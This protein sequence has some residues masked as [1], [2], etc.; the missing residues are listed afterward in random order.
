MAYAS[1]QDVEARGGGVVFSESDASSIETFIEDFSLYLDITIEQAGKDPVTMNQQ[2]L[3]VIAARRALDYY[4]YSEK[5]GVSSK[6]EA[7]GDISQT[8][9]FEASTK[10]SDDFMYLTPRD[11]Q[12]LGMNNSGFVSWSFVDENRSVL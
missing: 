4:F 11:K 2:V 3:K 1:I 10:T 12:M 9:S 6:T 8:L 7:V 5:N